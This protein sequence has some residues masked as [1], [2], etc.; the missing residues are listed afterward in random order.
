MGQLAEA[1][2]L[3]GDTAP[4]LRASVSGSSLGGVRWRTALE[5]ILG[6]DLPLLLLTIPIGCW[7]SPCATTPTT[8]QDFL[9]SPYLQCI[10]DIA[11]VQGSISSHCRDVPPP[12]GLPL[13][14]L[15]GGK[16]PLCIPENAEGGKVRPFL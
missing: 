7:S 4:V 15:E 3:P 5:P 12:R 8:A 16:Q 2:C 6:N 9:C 13:L 10:P 1:S 14:G 11:Q